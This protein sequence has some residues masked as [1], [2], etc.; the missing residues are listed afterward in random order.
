MKKY[1]LATVVGLFLLSAST[2]NDEKLT[3]E[4]KKEILDYLKSSKSELIKQVKGMTQEQWMF[5]PNDSTW[6]VA[7]I[8]EHIF[9]AEEVVLKRVGNIENMEYKPELLPSAYKKAEEFNSF[10]VGRSGKFKAPKPV[11]PEG[12][13]GSP[14]AFLEAFKSRRMETAK[15]VKDLDEPVKAY[16]ENFGPVGEVSGYHWLL[17]ISAHTERHTIQ[18]KELVQNGSFPS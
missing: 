14:E 13:F 12:N 11:Y 5:K 2:K 7:E 10:I 4:D 9:K 6:S 18:L 17:F 3:K 16:Y 8:C 15:Y 1:L